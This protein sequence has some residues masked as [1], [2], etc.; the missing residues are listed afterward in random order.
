MPRVFRAVA[1]GIV[2]SA[3]TVAFPALASGATTVGPTSGY[4]IVVKPIFATPGQAVY[5]TG[6][7]KYVQ[8]TGFYA[9]T[10]ANQTIWAT[11]TYYTTAGTRKTTTTNLGKS[12]V[13]IADRATCDDS[14]GCAADPSTSSTPTSRRTARWE[15]SPLR[16]LTTASQW[17]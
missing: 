4:H 17:P 5:V 10:C 8:D 15:Q 6:T 3:A 11:V 9:T 7:G 1:V 12:D 14:R 13:I 2:L 16:P